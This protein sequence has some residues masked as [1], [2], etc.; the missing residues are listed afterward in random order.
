MHRKRP[1]LSRKSHEIIDPKGRTL[2]VRSYIKLRYHVQRK[3]DHSHSRLYNFFSLI[4]LF[5]GII[6]QRSL[7]R[8][9]SQ[10]LSLCGVRFAN[11]ANDTK[12]STRRTAVYFLD[13]EA[14]QAVNLMH[15]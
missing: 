11:T 9:V 10:V 14:C 3:G 15:W 4:N 1:H 12:S 7:S 13:L 5:L 2:Q 6:A 8:Y